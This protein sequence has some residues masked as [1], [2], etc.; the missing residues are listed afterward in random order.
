MWLVSG[1]E[2]TENSSEK[3]DDEES[4]E[5]STESGSKS[6]PDGYGG[7]TPCTHTRP[8]LFLPGDLERP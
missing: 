6:P 3:E 2:D 7:G 4:S 5:E 1:G 8:R